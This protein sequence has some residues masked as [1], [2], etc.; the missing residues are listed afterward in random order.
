MWRACSP[1][2]GVCDL[3]HADD[4]GDTADSGTTTTATTTGEADD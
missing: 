3:A 2:D 1:I 4:G